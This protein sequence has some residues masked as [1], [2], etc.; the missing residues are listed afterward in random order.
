M[1]TSAAHT[2]APPATL[3]ARVQNHW[4]IENR[5]HRVRDVTYDE[6]RSRARTG[7]APQAMACL[8]NTAMS[9]L[10]PAGFPNIAAGLHHAS[11]PDRPI[12]LL[13]NS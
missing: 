7:Q 10:R 3:A 8:R 1:I 12:N 9:M 2:T 4:G 6:D 5:C 13:L 11:R